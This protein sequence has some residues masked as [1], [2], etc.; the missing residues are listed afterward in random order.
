MLIFF[1]QHLDNKHTIFGRIYSGMGII[2]R[3][4]NV[5]TDREDRPFEEVKIL[6]AK[7]DKYWTFSI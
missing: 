2:K 5:E 6:N 4:G 7:V 1:S 3:I